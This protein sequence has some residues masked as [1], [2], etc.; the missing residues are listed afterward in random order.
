MATR[1]PLQTHTARITSPPSSKRTRLDGQRMGTS[2]A[3]KISFYDPHKPHPTIRDPVM[4]PSFAKHDPHLGFT[5]HDSANRPE[6]AILHPVIRNSDKLT[7]SCGRFYFH[8]TEWDSRREKDPITKEWTTVWFLKLVRYEVF[9]RPGMW[10]PLQEWEGKG[11]RMDGMGDLGVGL[12]GGDMKMEYRKGLPERVVVRLRMV[13]EAEEVER[14][15]ASAKGGRR[16][17]NMKWA[18]EELGEDAKMAETKEDQ[19]GDVKMAVAGPEKF[20]AVVDGKAE[21]ERRAD[22]SAE[23]GAQSASADDNAIAAVNAGGTR[24]GGVLKK[25]VILKLGSGASKGR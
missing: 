20:D 3:H 4:N 10:P 15:V 25:R 21:D 11:P 1:F 19:G 9:P 22:E 5:P 12:A 23:A 14:I 17:V 7:H 2:I 24:S 8:E 6:A 13:E 16:Y 18:E